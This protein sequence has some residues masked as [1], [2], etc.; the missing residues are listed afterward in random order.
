[1]PRPKRENRED[2]RTQPRQRESRDIAAVVSGW[3]GTRH[4]HYR[5]QASAWL[6]WNRFS[7]GVVG[8]D[9]AVSAVA[10]ALRR[11]VGLKDPKR[12]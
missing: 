7:T 4:Q 1:M 5:G 10:R 12:P 3:T 9:E 2:I 8:L 11:D 6:K